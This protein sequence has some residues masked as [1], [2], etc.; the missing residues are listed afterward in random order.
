MRGHRDKLDRLPPGTAGTPVLGAAVGIPASVLAEAKANVA[1]LRA[2]FIVLAGPMGSGKDTIAPL[3]MTELGQPGSLHLYYADALKEEVD[4]MLDRLRTACDARNAASRLQDDFGVPPGHA[5][6]LAAAVHDE[7][8]ADPSLHARSRTSGIREFLQVL[9]TDVRRAADPDYWVRTALSRAAESL[10]EGRSVYVTDA[11][12]PNEI[13]A[14]VELGAFAVRL[15]V[16]PATQEARLAAR[17]GQPAA[18]G[19]LAHPSESALDGYTG[20]SCIVGNDG[21]A[22]ETVNAIVSAWRSSTDCR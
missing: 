9:G 12:F 22:G 11:R 15:E 3:V 2:V 1:S 13:D 17:D 20:Y 10:A 4:T 19:T 16:T 5:R 18:A 14:A 6:Q 8:A 7:L 21:P